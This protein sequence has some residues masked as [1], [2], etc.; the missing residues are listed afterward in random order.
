VDTMAKQT[1]AN[2]QTYAAKYIIGRPHV[3]GVLIAPEARQGLNLTPSM[4]LDLGVR[5]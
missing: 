3:T 2:L 1:P 4:L 5:P